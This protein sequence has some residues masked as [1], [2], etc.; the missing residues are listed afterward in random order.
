MVGQRVRAQTEDWLR[1][2]GITDIRTIHFRPNLA[3]TDADSGRQT[4]HVRAHE[5]GTTF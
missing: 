5:I 3:T 2:A 4:A 1:W